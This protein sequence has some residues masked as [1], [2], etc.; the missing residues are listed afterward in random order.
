[1]TIAIIDEGFLIVDQLSYVNDYYARA[2]K[3]KT[4]KL[5]GIQCQ[6]TYCGSRHAAYILLQWL[7]RQIINHIER[8]EKLTPI[9]TGMDIQVQDDTVLIV[10]APWSPKPIVVEG[11][12]STD[13]GHVTVYQNGEPNIYGGLKMEY[14]SAVNSNIEST[15]WQYYGK[16][17]WVYDK[18]IG[19]QHSNTIASP[20]NTFPSYL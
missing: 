1:M 13:N 8:I 17:T 4:T 10:L 12:P 14:N 5:D 11:W 20:F 18:T 16:D 2:D 3:V 9:T 15:F 6:Y 19:W 7:N